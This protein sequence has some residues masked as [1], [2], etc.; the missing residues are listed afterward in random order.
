M[1][2]RSQVLAQIKADESLHSI[3]VIVLTSSQAEADVL[4]SF[5]SHA[6]AY[7]TKPLTAEDFAAAT[8]SDS[9]SHTGMPSRARA[10][11]STCCA[12][13]SHSPVGTPA[14]HARGSSRS[15]ARIRRSS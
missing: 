3:P 4:A 9:V 6:N 1:T 8:V 12:R 10:R 7:I 11:S 5:S 14:P 15:A 2:P 13:G